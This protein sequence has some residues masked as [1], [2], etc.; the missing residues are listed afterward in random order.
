[1]SSDDVSIIKDPKLFLQIKK[2]S[3]KSTKRLAFFIIYKLCQKSYL[4]RS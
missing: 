1:M 4:V 2:N 3:P